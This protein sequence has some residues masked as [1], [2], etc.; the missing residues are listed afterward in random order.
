M[1]FSISCLSDAF[2]EEKTCQILLT[3]R[4]NSLNNFFFKSSINNVLHAGV[5]SVLSELN[6]YAGLHGIGS[7]DTNLNIMYMQNV[8]IKCH[9]HQIKNNKEE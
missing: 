5:K 8:S 4:I 9:T 7:G 6:Q 2:M 1:A 3:F